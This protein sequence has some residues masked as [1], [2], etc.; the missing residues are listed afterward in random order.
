M[1]DID[2]KVVLLMLLKQTREKS[3]FP[4]LAYTNSTKALKKIWPLMFLC[5]SPN[6]A[7]L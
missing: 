4:R 1:F 5:L 3:S 6:Y 7:Y 2:T